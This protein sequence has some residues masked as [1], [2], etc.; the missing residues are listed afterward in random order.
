MIADASEALQKYGGTLDIRRDS[1]QPLL[2][3]SSKVPVQRVRLVYEG[4]ALKPKDLDDLNTAARK[5]E[6][7]VPG[8]EVLFR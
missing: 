5:A 7:A 6:S 8:V 3:Q 2:R 4:S 1:L